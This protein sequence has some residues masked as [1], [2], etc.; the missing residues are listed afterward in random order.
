LSAGRIAHEPDDP[1]LVDGRL[2]G[3][4]LGDPDRLGTG[5]SAGR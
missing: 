1:G 4:T 5:L 2:L 3:L